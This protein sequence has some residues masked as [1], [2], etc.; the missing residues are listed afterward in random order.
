MHKL[1]CEHNL[2]G[3]LDEKYYFFYFASFIFYIY[4]NLIML[5][6]QWVNCIVKQNKVDFHRKNMKLIA[7]C[8][9]YF[10]LGF[11]TDPN[12]M[13]GSNLY[14]NKYYYNNAVG[15]WHINSNASIFHN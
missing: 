2:M 15:N 4:N 3:L 9:H 12:H 8:I 11:M 6:I 1:V 14:L 7:D 5:S 13:Q 10:F